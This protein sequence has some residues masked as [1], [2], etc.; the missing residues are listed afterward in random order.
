[1]QRVEG[2]SHVRGFVLCI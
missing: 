1:M 2:D